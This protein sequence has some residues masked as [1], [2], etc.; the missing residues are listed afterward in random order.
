MSFLTPLFLAAASVALVPVLL[1]LV[2]R[3]KAKEVPFSS[4]MFL[5]ATPMERIR[6]RKLRDILL[7]ALRMAMIVLLAT[8]FS[9][10]YLVRDSLPFVPERDDESVVIL[11]D[12]SLSMQA[13]DTFDEAL[14]ALTRLMAASSSGD[15]LALISFSDEAVQLSPLTRNAD[16]LQASISALRPTSRTTDYYP[17]L[18]LAEDILKDARHAAQRV[19]LISDLQQGGFSP[20]MDEYTVPNGV[21]FEPIHVGQQAY[22]NRYF[23]DFELT[24]RRREENTVT[25][26]D[27]RYHAL[28]QNDSISLVLE[29]EVVDRKFATTTGLGP[30]SFQHIAPRAGT[31]QGYLSIES[32]DL[33]ADNRHYFTYEVTARPSLLVVA[34]DRDAFFLQSAFELAERS[35]F[36]FTRGQRITGAALFRH[37]VV[38]VANAERLTQQQGTALR[39]FAERGGSVVVS[40][41]D[42]TTPAGFGLEQL[43]I[44]QLTEVVRTGVSE[45]RSAVIGQVETQHPIFSVL[46]GSSVLLRPSFRTYARVLPATGTAVLGSYDS[47]DPFLIEK[48][49]GQGTI[50]VYTSSFGTSWTDL[51]LHELFVPL[52]YQIAT[53]ATALG[54]R[55]RQFSVGDPVP[56]S[57]ASGS[58]WD[59]SAPG[60]AV[61]KVTMD[62]TGTGFFRET[63]GP[64][65]HVAVL[66]EDTYPFSVNTDA[67]E[68]VLAARGEA[69]TYAAI[70]GGRSDLAT[71][72]QE[73]AI[74]SEESE[75]ELKLWRI[76][77]LAV[78][79]LF[80]LETLLSH[81]SRAPKA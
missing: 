45:T 39:S 12:Q 59:V 62:T 79:G 68:S 5:Q 35:R 53:Y 14:A 38:F 81:R 77:I 46:A 63:G 25:R 37:D 42:A 57:G 3:M 30:V 73:A 67:R 28:A 49:I 75:Q 36:D 43:G 76:A 15:E 19:V 13:G 1:H 64:G 58:T 34:A 33:N 17:A 51:A 23:D 7:L 18:Q 10:P 22:A 54:E 31:Y 50:L 4:L 65:H 2:R 74:S 20:S 26:F 48:R 21:T 8:A 24:I 66:G 27:A 52:V 9:R 72:P 40:F 6:R 69:E 55:L 32:D 56:L 41:G 60:G 44:G 47:G 71:T 16:R 11:F 78:L 70:A 29:G 80:A 61:Y